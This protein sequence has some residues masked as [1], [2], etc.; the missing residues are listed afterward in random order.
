[1]YHGV[2]AKGSPGSQGSSTFAAQMHHQD[3]S[4]KFMK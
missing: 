3:E 4:A 1:V 2:P